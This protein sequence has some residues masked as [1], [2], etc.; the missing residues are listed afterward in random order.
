MKLLICGSRGWKDVR[1]IEALI[2]GYK[3]IADELGTELVVIHGNARG[4]DTIAET[5]AQNLGVTTIPC[6][7]DW[8]RYKAAAGPIRNQQMLTEHHPDVVYAFRTYGK[9][10][11]TDD[12]IG[13]SE[14]AKVPTFV[15]SGG[16]H[17]YNQPTNSQQ[18]SIQGI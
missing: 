15:V 11:G 14:K 9:S 4:A 13:K 16:E 3:R 6:P 7:A 2:A 12:M 5:V 17:P 1:P 18:L 10:S 8:A